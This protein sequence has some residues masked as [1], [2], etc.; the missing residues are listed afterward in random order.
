MKHFSFTMECWCLEAGLPA[1]S[2]IHLENEKL[3]MLPSS[4]FYLSLFYTLSF[5]LSLPL[6]RQGIVMCI[7]QSVQRLPV[8][9]A[10][11]S[12]SSEFQK[13]IISKI[14]HGGGLSWAACWNPFYSFKW[15][16]NLMENC[17]TRRTH[18]QMVSFAVTVFAFFPFSSVPLGSFD[19]NIPPCSN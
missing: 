18:F 7:F 12:L 16:N 9:L 3:H 19:R 2:R 6:K 14:W 8:L 13:C 10:G 17:F 4:I 1:F 5:S 15:W 11:L